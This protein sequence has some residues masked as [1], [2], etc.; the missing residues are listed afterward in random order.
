MGSEHFHILVLLASY[1]V[2]TVGDEWYE[3]GE[4]RRGEI[5]VNGKVSSDD[6]LVAGKALY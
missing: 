2:N 1:M 4:C 3:L 6:A 5:L